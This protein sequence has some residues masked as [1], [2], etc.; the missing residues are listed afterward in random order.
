[1]PALRPYLVKCSVAGGVSI[2]TFETLKEAEQH[3]KT[4]PKYN[5]YRVTGKP[6]IYKLVR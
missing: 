5:K 6:H 1:M 4:F 2:K 3:C